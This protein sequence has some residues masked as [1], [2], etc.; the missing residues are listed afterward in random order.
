MPLSPWL[1]LTGLIREKA[2]ISNGV[3][4]VFQNFSKTNQFM[5]TTRTTPLV[6]GNN[7]AF[8]PVFPYQK[9]VYEHNVPNSCP[10]FSFYVRGVLKC[11]T[12]KSF[13]DYLKA[14]LCKIGLDPNLWS[15]HSFRRGGA[16]INFS[17]G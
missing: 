6:P 17:L 1:N 16:T 10:A 7:L 9:L 15:G 3:V 13:T 5:A 14:L 2:I 11:V 4:L 8:N 12:R